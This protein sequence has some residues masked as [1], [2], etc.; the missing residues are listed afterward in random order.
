ML[1]EKSETEM[2]VLGKGGAASW[3]GDLNSAPASPPVLFDLGPA[4]PSLCT[5]GYVCLGW[6]DKACQPYGTG[7][8]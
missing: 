1:R 7:P 3:S 2:W 5:S 6:G 4:Y 8:L